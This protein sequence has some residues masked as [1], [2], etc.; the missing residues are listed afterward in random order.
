M[1][2]KS[3]ATQVEPPSVP[4]V[5]TNPMIS[6]EKPVKQI[7]AYA[8]FVKQSY[9]LMAKVPTAS[10]EKK[11]AKDVFVELAKIW[12]G[13]TPEKKDSFKTHLKAS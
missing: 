1:P 6:A 11:Q 2:K 3:K 13:M 7:T 12:A 5:A 8:N 10:G 9:P 4:P